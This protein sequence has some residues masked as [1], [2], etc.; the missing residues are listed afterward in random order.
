MFG[1]AFVWGGEKACKSLTFEEN[2]KT[3]SA[4]LLAGIDSGSV[5]INPLVLLPVQLWNIRTFLMD[6]NCVNCISYCPGVYVVHQF[7]VQIAEM[8]LIKSKVF[9]AV[10]KYK[11]RNTFAKMPQSLQTF[12]CTMSLLVSTL[13]PSE[14]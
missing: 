10:Y 9:M 4:S 1:F 11:L 7:G 14:S 3:A 13:P 12:I 5:D 2:K 6:L 8:L